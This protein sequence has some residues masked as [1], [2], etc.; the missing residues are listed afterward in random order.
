VLKHKFSKL[1]ATS[2]ADGD[3][4][5]LKRQMGLLPSRFGDAIAILLIV[6][7]NALPRLLP[8]APRRGRA[9]RAPEARRAR[10]RV[11]RGGKVQIVPADEVVPGDLLELEAG[12]AMPADARLVQSI[13]FA[14]EEAALTGESAGIVKDALAPVANDAPLADRVTMVFTGT[15]VVRGKGRA[16]VTATGVSTELGRIGE[17]IKSVGDQKTP[18]EERLDAFGKTILRVCL[19]LSAVLL[20]WGIFRSRAQA[21]PSPSCCS[22]R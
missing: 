7:L 12:D 1:E 18:L 20:G 5:A 11:R 22:R 3:L 13:D 8:G 2:G 15:T 21:A 6:V 19:A 14:T 10:A 16:V 17:M 9:R 4:E